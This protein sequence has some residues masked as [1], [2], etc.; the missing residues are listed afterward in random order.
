MHLGAAQGAGERA[1][2]GERLRAGVGLVAISVSY[3]NMYTVSTSATTATTN[4]D[5]SVVEPFAVACLAKGADTIEMVASALQEK[6][7]QQHY[8]G[9]PILAPGG[10]A[11]LIPFVV[12][13]T[14]RL[15]V[16]ARD[17][18]DLITK[19]QKLFGSL[20]L[21]RMSGA[22]ARGTGRMVCSAR[23]S[24]RMFT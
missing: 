19:E 6:T 12:E 5:V 17:L 21:D 2:T 8:H 16:A 4:K 18:Y 10:G 15:G 13:S 9:C 11:V 7:K 23:R 20:F 1:V 3:Y 22:L 14:G 24:L